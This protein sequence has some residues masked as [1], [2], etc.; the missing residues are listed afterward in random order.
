LDTC[1]IVSLTFVCLGFK[2]KTY[3]VWTIVSS[4]FVCSVGAHG[5]KKRMG[6]IKHM[7]YVYWTSLDYEHMDSYGSSM[8]WILKSKSSIHTVM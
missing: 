4:T 5:K 1:R 7:L 8:E 6:Q 2:E 3:V